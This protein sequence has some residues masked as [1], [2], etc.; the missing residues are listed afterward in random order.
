MT[1]GNKTERTQ[2]QTNCL[3]ILAKQLKHQNEKAPNKY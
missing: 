2:E 1:P 3:E